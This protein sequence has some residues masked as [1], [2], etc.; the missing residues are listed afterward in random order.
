MF[1]S[2]FCMSLSKFFV[3]SLLALVVSAGAAAQRPVVKAELDSVA[4]FVGGQVGLNVSVQMPKGEEAR[5]LP[6]PDTLTSHVEVVEMVRAD[7]TL[8]GDLVECSFRYL[9]T[10]FDTG[11]QYVPPIPFLLAADSTVVSMPDFALSVVNPFQ[12]ILVD[13]QSGVARIFDIRD[14]I[15]APFQ[16]SELLLYWPWLLVAA[17]VAGL[18]ALALWLRRRLARRGGEAGAASRVPLEPCEVTALRDLERIRGQKLWMHNKVKEFYSDLTDTLRRYVAS[19][20]GVQAMESTSSQLMEMLRGPLKGSPGEAEALSRILE[21]ADFAKFAKV[22]PLPDEND[23]AL[24]D[25]VNFVNATTDAARRA[26]EQVEK[27][28]Q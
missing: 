8:R 11:L 20:F 5:L 4:I 17:A 21:L 6:L 2:N 13:E 26:Q 15:D 24:T 28:E 22:E 25:A 10:S 18:I 1:F 9:L 12:K 19:R 14:A 23:R 16:W 27:K 3:S 7:T